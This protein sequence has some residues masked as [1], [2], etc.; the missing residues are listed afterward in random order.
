MRFSNN[1]AHN[2]V[3][4]ALGV[5]ERVTEA[6]T[7]SFDDSRPDS[8]PAMMEALAARRRHDLSQEEESVRRAARDMLRTDRFKPTGRSKPASEYLLG[9]VRKGDGV[10]QISPV[11][12]VANFLSLQHLVPISIWDPVRGDASDIVF[13]LGRAGESFVFNSAGHAID[14]EGLVCGCAIRKGIE[15]PIVNPVKDSMMTKLGPESRS[16]VMAVYLPSRM[17]HVSR[18]SALLDEA[19]ALM[20]AHT[21]FRL[22]WRAV[23]EAGQSEEL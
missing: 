19:A 18:S 20:S 23:L 21:S 7:T 4:L 1:L 14:V 3:T 15:V 10:P 13:R 9:A 8:L 12:D 2:P 16:A 6:I 11:V 17:F 22:G 5:F